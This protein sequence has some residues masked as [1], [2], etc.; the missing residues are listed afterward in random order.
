[1]IIKIHLVFFR[2]K[3]HIQSN[4][5]HHIDLLIKNL[6]SD[7]ESSPL[8]KSFEIK[9]HCPTFSEIQKIDQLQHHFFPIA[10]RIWIDI[11]V[12]IETNLSVEEIVSF[13]SNTP[14][15]KTQELILEV[16]ERI[17]RTINF[18]IL[19]GNIT[20]PGSLSFLGGRLYLEN[21]YLIELKEATNLY[22]EYFST[23]YKFNWP[24][25]IDISYIEVLEWLSKQIKP[26]NILSDSNTTRALAAFSNILFRSFTD[27]SPIDIMWLL[28]GLE[29]LYCKGSEGLKQQ[30]FEKSQLIL[31]ELKE[32]KREIKRMY[33][34]RSELIHGSLDL[35]FYFKK[36]FEAKE[37][38]TFGKEILSARLISLKML[39][40]TFQ[41]MVKN[42]LDNL[43]FI[44]KLC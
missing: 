10:P 1:M 29:A 15:N 31:G 39:I 9:K 11:F 14:P 36:E 35:P 22:A 21:N 3:F 42:K 18:G 6:C 12:P 13:Q 34:I 38:E 7:L 30:I 4:V 17:Q 28:M 2:N 40:V 32:Y 8:I 19:A 43:N 5:D 25:F 33:D 41:Y 37:L 16:D 27:E 23:G 24:E 20:N 26:G 44:Y